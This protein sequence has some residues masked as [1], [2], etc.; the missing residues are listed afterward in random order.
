[1]AYHCGMKFL[2]LI[3][4]VIACLLAGCVNC[5]D[6]ELCVKNISTDTIYFC[7]GCNY[8][9]DTLLP[10]E[11]ACIHVGEVKKNLTTS[12]YTYGD[13]FSSHGS[14]SILVDDCYVESVIE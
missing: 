1:M 13:F 5:K 11:Q 2:N 9:Q 10:Q 7:W 4:L 14:Y 12:Q 6:A 3:W 8:Y